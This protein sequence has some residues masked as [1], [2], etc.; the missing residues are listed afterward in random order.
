MERLL[1]CKKV[2][3]SEKGLQRSRMYENKKRKRGFHPSWKD[4]LVARISFGKRGGEDV[5]DHLRKGHVLLFW[6]IFCRE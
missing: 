1:A 4:S 5:L 6:F 2:K 3:R